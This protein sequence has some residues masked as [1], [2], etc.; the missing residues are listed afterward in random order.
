MKYITVSNES[1]YSWY[2]NPRVTRWLEGVEMHDRG[3]D[4]ILCPARVNYG[5][6]YYKIG[7]S[8][9]EKQMNGMIGY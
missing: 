1:G 9:K 8:N 3:K 4:V 7:A 5:N 2:Y 6:C